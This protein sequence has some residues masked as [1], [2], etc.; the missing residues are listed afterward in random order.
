VRAFYTVRVMAFACWATSCIVGVFYV[1]FI[2]RAANAS[3][4]TELLRR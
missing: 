1:R 3:S 2:T 4:P